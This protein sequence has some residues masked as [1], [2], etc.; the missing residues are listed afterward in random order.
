MAESTQSV[1]AE[2][3]RPV[4]SGASTARFE[5]PAA[6]FVFGELFE[7][8]PDARVELEPTVA[9]P[10][11]HAV[12]V[13]RADKRERT[14]V[15]DALRAD[16]DIV[17]VERFGEQPNGWMYRVT[18]DGHPRRLVDWLVAGGVTL[19]SV[20]GR[21]GQWRFRLVAP[22]RDMLARAHEILEESDC[23]VECRRISTF[24]GEPSAQ[25][26]LTERQHTA[27]VEAFEMGYYN[28]PRNVRAADLAEEL[29]I[30]HQALSERFRRAHKRLVENDLFIDDTQREKS[31]DR[32]GGD[33]THD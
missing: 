27:L 19:L 8:V 18:W 31:T 22:D 28:I 30:S 16:S 26:T 25:R 10:T 23:E 13:V 6:G 1:G 12:V 3:G 5:L 15:E 29:G 4:S 11:D 24:E 21:A 33:C 14:A 32:H 17:A 7:R 2:R 9:G 20:R